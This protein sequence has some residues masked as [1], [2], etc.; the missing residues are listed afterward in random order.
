MA[1]TRITACRVC[2]NTALVPV[3]EWGECELSGVFP[4]PGEA[5]PKG[6]LD[7]VRC[8]GAS[9][10]GSCG[11]LQLASTY[12]LGEMY[13]DN[14]GYRSGLNPVMQEHLKKLK[15]WVSG[16]VDMEGFR[17]RDMA[18][19]D[20]GSN[21]GTFLGMFEPGPGRLI[22]VDP[23]I[24][25]FEDFYRSDIEKV[26]DFF[27]S[28]SLSGVLGDTGVFLVSSIA[29]FYDLEDPGRFARTVASVLDPR[30]VWLF[31][32]SYLPDMLVKTSYD[33]V[34][35]EHL[36]Y[37]SLGVISRILREAD[38]RII[39]ILR[40][41]INGGSIA[42][43]AAHRGKGGEGDCETARNLIGEETRLGLYTD[44]PYKAFTRAVGEHAASLA[45][46]V[47]DLNR[48][49]SRVWGYGASTKGNI[50]LQQCGLGQADLRGILEVNRYKFGR[51]TPGT[52]I[53]IVDEKGVDLGAEDVLLM[54]PWHFH[55]FFLKKLDRLR[56]K[57]VRLLF[58]LPK[59]ELLG[60]P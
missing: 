6:S 14:Y 46:L 58:P 20:I 29:M 27:P 17:A 38:M 60:P 16:H 24:S 54:L 45:K 35:H 32:Q 36:E 1:G 41:D 33:T 3:L 59:I 4:L 7:L 30:G 12:P 25:K 48:K 19:L 28:K 42:V 57:G 50:I 52:N 51:V 9:G 5:V 18:V 26:P 31:E 2:G 53:P 11:L 37:Y 23:T 49:G 21:D 44:A 56:R 55:D 40:N 43:L 47:R 34:C 10:A 22:G 39:N 13:G 15:E 8:G